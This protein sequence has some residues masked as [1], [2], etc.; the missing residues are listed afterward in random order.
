MD[1]NFLR[2]QI[3]FQYAILNCFVCLGNMDS[4]SAVNE[5]LPLY[6]VLY[7]K[8]VIQKNST[9]ILN[10][11]IKINTVSCQAKYYCKLIKLKASHNFKLY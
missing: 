10:I 6:P 7:S 5:A 3:F 11:A 1:H 8:S 2:L 9:L 4:L